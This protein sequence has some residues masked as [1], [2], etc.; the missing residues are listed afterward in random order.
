MQVQT[1]GWAIV[2]LVGSAGWPTAVH[3]AD[4][5][6]VDAVLIRVSPQAPGSR[7][8][9]SEAARLLRDI[10]SFRARTA[11]DAPERASADWLAL[12]D[13]ALEIEPGSAAADYAAF[14]IGTNQPVGLRSVIAALPSPAAWPALRRAAQDRAVRKPDD[15]QALDLKLVTD[16]LVGDVAAMRNSLAA[17]DRIVGG[18]GPEVRDFKRAQ[19]NATRSMVFKLHGSREE[20]ADAFRAD[21]EAQSRL[22]YGFV[23]V[24]DLVGMLGAEK[25]GALLSDALKRPVSI[26]VPQGEATRALARKLALA[27]IDLLRKPQWGLIDGMGTAALYEAMQRRFA[28]ATQ[29]AKAALADE[30]GP[31]FDYV[32]RG[33]DLFYF[34]DMVVAGRSDEAERAMVRATRDNGLVA[35]RQAMTELVRTGK[36]EPVYAYLATLLE[37]RPELPAWDIYLEQAAALGHASDAIA[38]LDRLLKRSGLPDYLRGGLFEKRLDA[39]LG[40]DRVDEAAAG[41]RQLLSSPPKRDDPKLG[42]RVTLA[43]R[44]AGLGRALRQLDLAELGLG[45]AAQ[46]VALPE[47][48]PTEWRAVALHDLLGELRRQGRANEAQSLALAEFDRRA[49]NSGSAGLEAIAGDPLKRSALVELAG[50]YDA[51]SRPADVL[52]LL[53]G[54]ELWA[55]RDLRS[56]AAERDSLGTPLGLMA[57]RALK[58]AGRPLEA[59]AATLA[60]LQRMPGHDPA[61]QLLVDVEPEA[62]LVDLERMSAADAFEER[63]LIWRAFVLRRAG[64]L[65]LAEAQVRRAI[66]IDP[67]DGE[68]GPNDR[69]RAY[70]VLADI[71]QAKGDDKGSQVYRRAVAAI[72]TSEQADDLRKLGLY[73]RAA[74]LYRAAL[75]E[76]S[77]AY[78]IQSRLA[79]QLGK[80]GL[81]DEA[82]KHYRRAFELMPESFG[83]VESHC[84]GCESVF[85]GPVAQDVAEQVFTSLVR[86]GPLTPQAPY[87]LGY[88]RMEQ[89][90][91]DEAI[92]LFR[93][94]VAL[95]SQY[96]NAWKRLHELGDKT[97]MDPRERDIAR[98]KLFELDPEQRHV[99]YELNEVSDLK[100]LWRAIDA[101]PPQVAGARGDI[102]LLVRSAAA[103]DEALARLP[104]DMRQ[105]ISR[106]VDLQDRIVDRSSRGAARPSLADH[107]LLAAVV[108]M[109]G[110]RGVGEFAD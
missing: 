55:A 25:G 57:A 44:V 56:I 64:Q 92:V 10:E 108:Q 6:S 96:L 69:M 78:C 5:Q 17:F 49:G 24:P 76:F 3:A 97:Y 50:I 109:V 84:F 32:Q 40:A 77:D 107:G 67:S 27:Q 95:D 71:L 90:R 33:A 41:F 89:G 80:M 74:A 66:S 105:Q 31:D 19:I 63:P 51:A 1:L 72:R 88:L 73:V 48:S 36:S 81:Q 106:Y 79:V 7:S 22:S 98:L 68:Q 15:L 18:M 101:Q 83:R 4:L 110:K 2:F 12:W 13:R 52:R 70:S 82:L 54:A 8:E 53:D 102:H 16:A 42:A 91:F 93:Q 86:R 59:K 14:D 65:D 21:V 37:R 34:L 29:D 58:A 104:P 62:A 87:M 30:P 60:V 46:A 23:R 61:Y 47:P 94:V 28:P 103:R 35:A 43:I 20:I 26:Q 9:T 85:A 39:L 45:Y 11:R 100:A 75:D 38:L 99:R